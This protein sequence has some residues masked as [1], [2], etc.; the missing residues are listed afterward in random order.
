MELG[1]CMNTAFQD[2]YYIEVDGIPGLDPLAIRPMTTGNNRIEWET[3]SPGHWGMSG[4][5]YEKLNIIPS[6]DA[7]KPK[8][9]DIITENNVVTLTPLTLKTYNEK[10]RDKLAGKPEFNNDDELKQFFLQFNFY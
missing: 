7:E 10:V 4:Y 8:R 9:I 3:T 2:V 6:Q 5:D 1:E